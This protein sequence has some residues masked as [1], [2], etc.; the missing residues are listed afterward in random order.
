MP[1]EGSF[2][3][4]VCPAFTL[5][6]GVRMGG[7]SR[8]AGNTSVCCRP[9]LMETDH[10]RPACSSVPLDSCPDTFLPHF[11]ILKMG[12]TVSVIFT[13]GLLLLFAFDSTGD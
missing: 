8:P 1:E 6:E 13:D 10:V 7:G 4:G 9:L 11:Q 3:L 2:F 5:G 12:H